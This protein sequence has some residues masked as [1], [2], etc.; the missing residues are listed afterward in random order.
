MF[1]EHII[2]CS[3]YE[4]PHTETLDRVCPNANDSI[5]T[6]QFADLLR[7]D[8]KAVVQKVEMHLP[9]HNPT[10]YKYNTR[11]S[12]VYRFDFPRPTMPNLEIDSNGT[13]RL[14]QDNVWVNPWNPAIA[15]LI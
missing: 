13:I 6:S 8:S 10:C 3:A 5:T 15:S 12:K 2:K 7:A 11:K 14:R 4:D 1:L 9:Y